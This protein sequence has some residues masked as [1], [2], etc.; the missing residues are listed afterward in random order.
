M[1][2][3]LDPGGEFDERGCADIGQGKGR[4]CGQ[5]H[6]GRQAPCKERR[7]RQGTDEHRRPPQRERHAQVPG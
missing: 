7:G 5:R 3:L 4:E 1:P 2:G 6:A